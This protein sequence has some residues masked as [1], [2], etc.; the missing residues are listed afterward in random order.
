MAL[1]T[2][3][4]GLRLSIIKKEKNP[5]VTASL[6]I[7]AGTQSE[8]NYESG[9]SVFTSRMLLMGIK[10]HPNYNELMTYA[11]SNGI[12]LTADSTAENISV[13]AKT[14]VDN[15]DKAMELLCAVAFDST[16]S[17]DAAARVRTSLL[18][19]IDELQLNSSYVLEK[20]VNQALYHRTGLANPKFGTETTV[21]RMTSAQAKDYFERVFTPK[22]TVVSVV[23]DVDSEAVYDKVMKTIYSRF[24]EGGEFKKLKFVAPVD[25][26][27]GGVR[28][29]NK[30]LNQSRMF[31][32]FPG[33][34]YKDSKK[35]AL[36]I[37]VPML[38]G[39]LRRQLAG[40]DYF[41]Q[42]NITNVSYANNGKLTIECM[43][44]FDSVN[45]YLDDLI[46]AVK[47]IAELGISDNQFEIEKNAYIVKY[48]EVAESSEALGNM[49]AKHVAI[50]KAGFSQAGELMKIELLKA[51]DA[52]SIL[53]ELFDFTKL[54]IA[55]LGNPVEIDY[56]KYVD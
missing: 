36:D 7:N 19:E 24:I 15:F 55:Y 26:F 34:S 22:N 12:V 37:C 17:E 39:M 14:T 42:E 33:L 4:N 52:N 8:K 16:F 1:K 20:M 5:L 10:N 40:T 50:N 51:S 45:T 30:R 25:D 11:K 29:K 28:T 56:M 47:E 31:L 41:H 32:S 46:A 23:G 21:S 43:V 53:K 54:Y 44:D 2:Y 13:T 9:I 38:E 48:L 49:A 18:A 27:I 6:Y 3:P 35:Y